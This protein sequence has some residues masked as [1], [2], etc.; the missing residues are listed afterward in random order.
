LNAG[1]RAGH[2]LQPKTLVF[3]KQRELLPDMPE[4]PKFMVMI[5][6]TTSILKFARQGEKTGWS[7]IPVTQEQAEQLLP[8]TRQSFRVKG[9][10]DKVS[11]QAM[12]LIPMGG[13]SFILP[14]KADL[15]KKLGKQAGAVVEVKLQHDQNEPEL[16]ADFMACIKDEPEA[17]TYFQTLTKGHQR[18]FSKWIEE[19]R[20]GQTQAKRI[21]MAINALQRKMG[22]P[23]ML[24]DAKA[25]KDALH[26]PRLP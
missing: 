26:L 6:F 4:S 23:E 12:A 5:N 24:R 15:R 22:F 7:Y 2:R 13:G 1:T 25:R 18:Y 19:A 21:A 16:S 11:I 20:T 17:L 10:L 8:G 14:L 9:K 3:K